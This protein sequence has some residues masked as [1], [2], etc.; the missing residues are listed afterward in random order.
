MLYLSP[1]ELSC[2][3]AYSC[4][5]DALLAQNVPNSRSKPT[6]ENRLTSVKL[7]VWLDARV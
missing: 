3:G 2:L 4:C 5:R 6:G 1:W 7:D